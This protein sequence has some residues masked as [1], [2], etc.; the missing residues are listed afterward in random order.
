MET[1]IVVDDD[2]FNLD[3]T[4]ELLREL[5]YVVFS[6]S[7]PG[8][9]IDFSSGEKIDLLVADVSLPRIKGDKLAMRIKKNQP[10]VRVLLISGYEKEDIELNGFDFL[11]KPFTLSTLKDKIC[12]SF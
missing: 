2:N 1:A 6:F 10:E 9:A 11:H 4:V 3:I 12:K 5:G 8:E 7:L